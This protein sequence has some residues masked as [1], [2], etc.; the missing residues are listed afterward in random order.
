ML[1]VAFIMGKMDSGGKKNLAMEYF[2][3]MDPREVKV[4]FICDSDSAAVPEDEIQQLGGEYRYIAPYQN[5]VRNMS[6]L[7][8]LCKEERFDVMHAFNSTM[9]LFPLFVAKCAHIPMRIS[10]SLSMAHEA[11]AKTQ[12]KLI[13][14]RFSHLFATHYMACGEDCG[15]WQ[16]GNASFERGE[17]AVFKTAINSAANDYDELLRMKTRDAFDLANNY[18][19]GFIGRFVPQKNPVFMIEVFA[20]IKTLNKKAK[21]LLIGDGPLKEEMFSRAKELGVSEDILY[22]GRREDIH[23]FYLAMDCFL[24]PSLYEGLP[25]VG[26]ESQC[27]GLPV[28]F[29]TE[30]TREA[31]FCDIAHYLDLSLTAKQWGESIVEMSRSLPPRRSRASDCREAGF[32]SVEEA[33]RLTSYYEVGVRSNG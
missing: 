23:Q 19:V 15:R 22:L 29:S 7:F 25:V 30:I 32:D 12:L 9:N 5:I 6:D 24:L 16:F 2:R 11:E 21:L 28:V 13:L 31:A 17:V 14:R 20:A 4:Y 8:R 3:H 18:V 1:K 10:E 33:K 27:C 26:L